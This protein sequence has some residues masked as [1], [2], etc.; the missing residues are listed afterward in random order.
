[1]AK[2]SLASNAIKHPLVLEACRQAE[3]RTTGARLSLLE[4][5]A[6]VHL[7]KWELAEAEKVLDEYLR[8]SPG[9]TSLARKR[10]AAAAGVVP[11]P[12]G[13][14]RTVPL[15]NRPGTYAAAFIGVFLFAFGD[16]SFAA[17]ENLVKWSF[18]V[19][20]VSG[21][22]SLLLAIGIGALRQ[23]YNGLRERAVAV[24][25]NRG[26][27]Y[28]GIV[29]PKFWFD[30]RAH[31]ASWLLVGALSVWASWGLACGVFRSHSREE[32]LLWANLVLLVRFGISVGLTRAYFAYR[33]SS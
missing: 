29:P 24:R 6:E 13:E 17:F 18:W 25:T 14:P 28:L 3:A 26:P 5:Q 2:W 1:M 23:L 11:I 30:V 7:A 16:L 8:S 10:A 27:I 19:T 33:H 20:T 31:G 22:V 12:G 9:N 21:I 32:F 4:I 15:L